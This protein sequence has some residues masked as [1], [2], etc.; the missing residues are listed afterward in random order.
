MQDT[1]ILFFAGPDEGRPYSFATAPSSPRPEVE[2]K[3]TRIKDVLKSGLGDLFHQCLGRIPLF[4]WVVFH[5][6]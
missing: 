6:F 4:F 5:M 1:N 3:E 2:E